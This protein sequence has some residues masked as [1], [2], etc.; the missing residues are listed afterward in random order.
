M[1]RI[2]LITICAILLVLILADSVRSR[3]PRSA[4]QIAVARL[5]PTSFHALPPPV[6]AVPSLQPPP[7]PANTSAA[8]PV[9]EISTLDLYARL[10]IRRRL[11]RE[12]NRV[13]IDSLLAH[14]DSMVVR[15]YDHPVVTVALVADT[16]IPGWRAAFLSDARAG[17]TAWESNPAG[18]TFR[19][20]ERPDSADIVVRWALRLPDS[21]QAGV[22]Q[23]NWG[24]DGAIASAGM[25]LALHRGADTTTIPAERRRDVAAHEFGHALGL[26][27]SGSRDDLMFPATLVEAP[28]PRDIATLRLL[29]AVPP[30]SL[31]V[32]F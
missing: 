27:H 29:Y 10:A 18:I 13:Y 26:G 12:G 6:R 9:A 2:V 25:T 28:Y 1:P 22:T 16:T 5:A 8:S 14:T 24:S 20:V 17:M 23:V 15:W 32:T 31:H 11:D 4:G 30:G 21:T 7:A 3:R 19:E